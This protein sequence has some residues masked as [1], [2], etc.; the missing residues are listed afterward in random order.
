[1]LRKE[2]KDLVT[3]TGP[4]ASIGR[5]YAAAAEGVAWEELEISLGSAADRRVFP[6]RRLSRRALKECK[7]PV[8]GCS[9]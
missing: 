5:L 1:M 8:R 4:G 3:Q 9:T 6:Q 7:R 2:G